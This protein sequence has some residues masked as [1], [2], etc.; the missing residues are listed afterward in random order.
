M[1]RD[2]CFVSDEFMWWIKVA[3][4]VLEEAGSEQLWRIFVVTNHSQHPSQNI[5]LK[6]C[7]H[8]RLARYC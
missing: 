4:K 6:Y 2:G 3:W 7:K 1:E 5:V 8:L